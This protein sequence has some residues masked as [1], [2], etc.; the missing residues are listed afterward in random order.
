MTQGTLTHKNSS[1]RF[2][3]GDIRNTNGF[4]STDYQTAVAN[5]R[6]GEQNVFLSPTKHKN[7]LIGVESVDLNNESE[8]Q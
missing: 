1:P 6:N 5:G 4:S 7:P 2:N 8:T 3:S